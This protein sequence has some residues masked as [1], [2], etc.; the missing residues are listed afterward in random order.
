MIED[1]SIEAT[2]TEETLNRHRECGFEIEH[3]S[4]LADGMVRAVEE[5]YDVVLLDLS[6]PDGRGLSNLEQLNVAA[7]HVPVI[8]LTNLEDESLA[9]KAVALG[10]QDYLIKGEMSDA[11]LPRS[12]RYAIAR[13]EAESALRESEE[14]YALAVAGASDGVW[15]WNLTSGQVYYSPRW[16]DILGLPVAHTG[17]ISTWLNRIHEDDKDGFDAA[18]KAHLAGST[19]H[20]EHEHRIHDAVGKINWV[21]ARGVV[22]RD[23]GGQPS[24]MAGSMTDIR[25]RKEAEEKLVHEA[26]HDPLTSLPNRHLFLDRLQIALKQ[27][28]RDTSRGFAVLF[29]DL[30]KFKR[31]NDSL[32]H[33]YGDDLLIGVAHRLSKFL[34]PSD[35][36]ARLGGDE[37][38]IL[39]ADVISDEQARLIAQ[40]INE[41]F[42]KRFVIRGKEI[43]VGASI[44]IAVSRPKYDSVEEV[45]RDADLAMYRIK[46]TQSSDYA[47]YDA[48]MH[49]LA[50]TKLELEAGIRGVE[51]REELSVDYQP[52]VSLETMQLIGFEALLRWQHPERGLIPP[53]DFIPIAE[54]IGTIAPITWW[55]LTAACEQLFDWQ[56]RF[57]SLK[58]LSVSVNISSHMFSLPNFADNT[59][60]VL[61]RTGLDPRNLRLEI[62]EN[63]LLEHHAEVLTEL[64]TLRSIGV[65]LELDDFGTGYSSLSYLREFPY[66]AIKIDRSFITSLDVSPDNAR[67]VDAMI[68][69]ADNLSMKVVAEGVESSDQAERLKAL[70]CANAQGYW[71]SAPLQSENIDALLQKESDLRRIRLEKLTK[72]H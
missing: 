33:A 50:V 22:I 43:Q 67:I 48:E 70:K 69:L 8:I 21:L 37:F 28:Q 14:R 25:S 30:D 57:S 12:I 15:D 44:G 64:E 36:I 42:A 66:D 40:R 17:Q 32:G 27:Y 71:F 49:E 60:A 20:F 41:L 52:I 11:L 3:V 1:D 65:K 7:P 46:E 23:A 10:A 59:I 61:E 51:M 31:I 26:L 47:I 62:T 24:R 4:C 53:E 39:A 72:S 58:D 18:L 68:S 5:E 56:E 9:T 19:E 35:S 13:H 45:L 54:E 55:T 2:L 38:A 29:L 34:R 16:Y 6:L 63:A